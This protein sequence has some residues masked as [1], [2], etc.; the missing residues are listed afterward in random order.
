MNI[1]QLIKEDIDKCAQLLIQSYNCPPWNHQ[2]DRG[3]AVKYLN[4]YADRDR[5]VGFVLCEDDY[6]AGAMFGH[7]K[8]WWTNDLLYVDELFISP[9]RQRL[10]YGKLLL[11]H[12][13]QYAGEKG[14][15]V[16]SL[17]TSKYMPAFKFYK[18][19]DYTQAEHFVYFFK[20]V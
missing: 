11:S 5:F 2:W 9:G 20:S 19:I 10:G 17:M 4:E 12:T 3:K 6:I 14:Y 16:V 8:T 1:R 18:S 7:S 13:E 15:D